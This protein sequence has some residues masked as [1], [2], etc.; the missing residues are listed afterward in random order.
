MIQLYKR[1]LNT[2]S[3]I[4][5]AF[6]Y[7]RLTYNGEKHWSLRPLP[8][9]N[10]MTKSQQTFRTELNLQTHRNCKKISKLHM[11]KKGKISRKGSESL[12][13]PLDLSSNH[14][15]QSSPP[16]SFILITLATMY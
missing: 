10:V 6:L 11:G 3:L 9:L 13:L 14:H 8:S 2:C 5:I 15:I 1:V 7:H 12:S 4:Y 16:C